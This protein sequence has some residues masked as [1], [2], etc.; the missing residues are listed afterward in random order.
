MMS[1]KRKGAITMIEKQY[2]YTI[3][4]TKTIERII[5]DENV[6]INHMVLREGESLPEH[7]SNS[8]V[9]MAVIRG[10]ISLC[11]DEQEQHDYRAGNI[12]VIPFKTKMNVYNT[13]QDVV[14]I[15]VI[16]APSPKSI[17]SS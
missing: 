8:N 6:A 12:I 14:E 7:Y 16:K 11:L 15:F 3:T 4:D 10:V 13:K 5:E 2:N 1:K 17:K 9:Y